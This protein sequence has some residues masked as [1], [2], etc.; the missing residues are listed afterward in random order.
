MTSLSKVND[1][2]QLTLPSSTEYIGVVRLLI[3]GIAERMNFKIDDIEDIKIAI[4]EACTNSVLHAYDENPNKELCIEIIRKEDALEII[5]KD[6]GKGFDT[7]ILQ[8]NK[9]DEKIQAGALTGLGLG[10]TFIKS[11]MDEV[12]IESNESE[13]SVIRMVKKL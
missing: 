7:N 11:L 13:G 10:F 9:L 1:V 6:F 4:S 3:S 8:E 2:F 12:D 5:V